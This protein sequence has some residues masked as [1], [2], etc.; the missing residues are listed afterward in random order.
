M[1]DRETEL[2]RAA[3]AVAEAAGKLGLDI[4]IR[5]MADSTRTAEEAAAACGTTVGRIVK[6][7]VFRGEKSGRPILLLVSGDNRVKENLV[8]RQIG[9]KI[10]RPDAG[11]VREATGFAI[12][13]IPPFGHAGGMATFMDADLLAHPT[14]FAAAGTPN[15]IFEAEPQALQ[16]ACGATVIA[17]HD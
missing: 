16:R 1:Q 3:R 15:A 5:L 2:P 11:F 13:G 7:L 9:E 10:A 17:V 6:S 8:A 4:R 12:G 14:V